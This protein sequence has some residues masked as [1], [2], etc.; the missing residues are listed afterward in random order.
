VDGPGLMS[1][2]CEIPLSQALQSTS[3]STGFRSMTIQSCFSTWDHPSESSPLAAD[4]AAHISIRP[5][6]SRTDLASKL[7]ALFSDRAMLASSLIVLACN[8][9]S[10]KARKSDTW[11]KSSRAEGRREHRSQKHFWGAQRLQALQIYEEDLEEER[12]DF[13]GLLLGSLRTLKVSLERLHKV[14]ERNVLGKACLNVLLNLGL[15]AA[16]KAV[17]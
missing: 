4:I 11:D 7:R 9:I 10:R 16:E 15:V 13:G 1:Q 2:P 6:T 12:D 14:D 5:S 3:G 8:I 17:N